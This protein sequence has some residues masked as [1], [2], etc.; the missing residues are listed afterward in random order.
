MAFTIEQ[1][2]VLI[3]PLTTYHQRQQKEQNKGHVL[4]HAPNIS[5]LLRTT[6]CPSFTSTKIVE[7]RRTV[8][9][10]MLLASRFTNSFCI[11]RMSRMSVWLRGSNKITSSILFRNSGRTVL[12]STSSTWM[13]RSPL[14][15]T[16]QRG[17]LKTGNGCLVLAFWAVLL[18]PTE[19]SQTYPTATV[20]M[21]I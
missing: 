14:F 12:M 8:P 17:I 7:Y 21:S 6:I 2:N 5:Y 18:V 10:R 19:P 4:F 11:L 20:V 1:S 3:L 9:S 16:F 13:R 15:Q